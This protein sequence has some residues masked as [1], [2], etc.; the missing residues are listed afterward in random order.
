MQKTVFRELPNEA[1]HVIYLRVGSSTRPASR[2]EKQDMYAS[3]IKEDC[4]LLPV[5]DTVLD[6]LSKDEIARYM[7][8][9]NARLNDSD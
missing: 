6:D 7:Q 2:E 9:R 8:R 1:N 3:S 5:K 4:D